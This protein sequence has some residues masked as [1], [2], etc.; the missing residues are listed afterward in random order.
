[1]LIYFI[2]LLHCVFIYLFIFALD[3]ECSDLRVEG[4]NITVECS[5]YIFGKWKLLCKDQCE[6]GNIL[7]ETAN[8]VAQ[9]G[10]YFMTYKEEEFPTRHAVFSVSIT[11]LEKSD[12]GLYRC[13]LD[14][15]LDPYLF[16][17]F[18]LMV[19]EGERMC[20]LFTSVMFLIVSLFAASTLG[21]QSLS[22]STTISKQPEITFLNSGALKYILQVISLNPET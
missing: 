6:R 8:V 20:N 9:S 14:R 18:Q 22:T 16:D 5:F 13:Y 17:S 2:K 10:R 1:T 19:T 11:Q 3:R 12:S 15:N 4:G 7:I 21:P